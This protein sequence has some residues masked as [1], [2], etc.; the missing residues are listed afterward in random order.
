[1]KAKHENRYPG[2]F[3]TGTCWR[4]GMKADGR[5]VYGGYW[6]TAREA[7]VA[8][9]RLL[10]YFGRDDLCLPSVSRKLG[11]A[12]PDELK[13]LARRRR[14]ATKGASKYFGVSWDAAKRRWSVKVPL[15]GGKYRI[16]GRYDDERD[17]GVAY[18]R[19]ARHLQQTGQ[20]PEPELNFPER[21]LRATSVEDLR[22]EAR[23]AFRRKKL[24]SPYIGVRKRRDAAR[25]RWQ[26]AIKRPGHRWITNAGGW[27][28]PEEA[29]LAF[30]RAARFYHQAGPERLN[31]PER[32]AD[33][34]PADVKTLA[35][36]ARDLFKRQSQSR[37]HGITRTAEGRWASRFFADRTYRWL[38]VFDDEEDAARAYDKEALKRLGR[39]ARLNF[40]PVTGAE[41]RGQRLRD[42]RRTP[43]R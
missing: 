29:A 15:K 30:D 5:Q 25:F 26:A 38:G 2:I 13:Q 43:A 1:M 28:T 12:S 41:L 23:R 35:R 21:R 33:T 20:G 39:D 24:V 4:V 34:S 42:L 27:A 37:F 14:K 18:D 10:L 3:F 36:E 31:F 17:A 8:R 40:H 19:A 22:Q 32:I 11:P 16:V 6:S 9:D 7:A